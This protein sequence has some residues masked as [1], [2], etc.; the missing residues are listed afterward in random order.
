M[1]GLARLRHLAHTD[2]PIAHWREAQAAVIQCPWHE[3]RVAAEYWQTTV[4]DWLQEAHWA[5]LART[6]HRVDGDLQWIA[7]RAAVDVGAHAYF[8]EVLVEVVRNW[9]AQIGLHGVLVRFAPS[10]VGSEPPDEDIVKAGDLWVG[11]SVV[12][13]N[14]MYCP[15]GDLYFVAPHEWD[16]EWWGPYA[17]AIWSNARAC[18]E[19]SP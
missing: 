10:A 11:S 14:V 5:V 7:E 19:V 8:G 1:T 6:L 17:Q 18:V 4:D 16:A 2:N 13:G 15:W 9:L 3:R 12:W